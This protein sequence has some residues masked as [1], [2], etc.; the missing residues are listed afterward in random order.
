MFH[1]VDVSERLHC[2]FLESPPFS[3]PAVVLS[4][5][6]TWFSVPFHVTQSL[7]CCKK[8]KKK[9]LCELEASSCFNMQYPDSFSLFLRLVVDFF[10]FIFYCPLSTLECLLEVRMLRFL[11]ER[12]WSV[13][14]EPRGRSK[15]VHFGSVFF[16]ISQPDWSY[17]PH[18]C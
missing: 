18:S 15:S 6:L 17:L 13:C 16:P 14:L 11:C 7:H 9:G 10:W 12:T 1:E 5:G 8:E 4:V 2:L 3:C